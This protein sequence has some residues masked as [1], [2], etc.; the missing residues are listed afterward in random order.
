MRP[1]MS[2]YVAWR[3]DVLLRG[4]AAPALE[5]G[6]RLLVFRRAPVGQRR[7]SPVT[8]RLDPRKV[9]ARPVRELAGRLRT[10]ARG[11]HSAAPSVSHG[12]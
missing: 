9:G 7:E 8:T 11:A 1:P 12:T 4:G 6:F 10:A 3:M 5:V 2:C